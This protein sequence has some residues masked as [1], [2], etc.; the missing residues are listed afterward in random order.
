[1][2]ADNPLIEIVPDAPSVAQRAA[3]R[4]TDAIA[5]AVAE[6]GRCVIALSGGSTPRALHAV[7][8]QEPLR[9]TISWHNLFVFWGDE[10][11][12]LPSHPESNYQMARDTLL[13]H[14]PIPPHHIHR[15]PAEHPPAQ[16]AAAYAHTLRT[17]LGPDVPRFDLILLGMGPDGHTAS[18]FPGTDALALTDLAGPTTAANWVPRLDTWRLTLTYPVL[19]NARA[20]LFLAAGADKAARWQ[21]AQSQLNEPIAPDTLPCARVRP[22]AG[23]LIWLIDRAMAGTSSA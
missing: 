12:V 2:P 19:N 14:V 15:W 7:L 9:S 1:M 21:E 17:V 13:D 10:R 4:V 6:R 23:H 22:L 11:C 20:I 3:E 5:Q 8:A 16:A 18:L